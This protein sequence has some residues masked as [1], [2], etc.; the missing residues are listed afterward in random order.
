LKEEYWHNEAKRETTLLHE[1]ELH[2]IR[3]S[4]HPNDALHYLELTELAAR[5]RTREL[6]PVEVTRAQLDR[7]ADLDDTLHSYALV[8][9]DAAMAHHI[10]TEDATVVRRL[11]EAGAAFQDVTTWHGRHPLD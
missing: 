6:S 1:P 9:A 10:P 7:I 3:Y 11:K 2:G 5:I 4:E 8:M